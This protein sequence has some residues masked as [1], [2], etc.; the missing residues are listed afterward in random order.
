MQAEIEDRFGPVPNEVANLIVLTGLK[1]RCRKIGLTRIDAG[2]QAI[3]L[4]FTERKAGEAA[5]QRANGKLPWEWRGDRLVLP[6][7]TE[8]ADRLAIVD[9][10]V[11]GLGS[12]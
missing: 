8:E 7:A 10:L 6:R 1:E 3:A 4:T 2:P 9:K 5:L 11:A 12:V